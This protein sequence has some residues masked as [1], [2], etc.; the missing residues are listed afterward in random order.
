ML[1]AAALAIG[2]PVAAQSPASAPDYI[3][4]AAWLCL[5]GRADACA[6][7]LAATA[8]TP[9][10]YGAVEPFRRA[11]NPPLDCF[12]VYPTVSRDTTL[13]A[14]MEPGPAEAAVAA[15]QLARFASVCRTFAPLYRQVTLAGILRRF[16]GKPAAG[17]YAMAYGDVLAAW[18]NFLATRNAS[19]PFVLI[20]HSQGTV[21]LQQLLTRE[22]EG[23]PIAR[24]MVSALLIGFNTLVP[25]GK[26]VGGTF[27]S[28]PLCTRPAQTG[29]VV[30][31]VSY[32][33]GREPPADA[34][35]GRAPR[36]GMTVACTNPAAL[37]SARPASLR[38]YFY[39]APTLMGGAAKPWAREGTLGTQFVTTDG[40]VTGACVNRGPVGVLALRVNA[41]PRDARADD[42]PGD[43]V[44][45]GVVQ[46]GWG[47][48]LIDVNV[49]QGDLVRLV[50]RQAR[51]FGR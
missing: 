30:A 1:A 7:P 45:D 39:V 47:T 28:T 14:D 51:A 49:A 24:Q 46:A 23:K 18:R 34:L 2:A 33:A 41:D 4:D 36:P 6:A 25:E 9:R 21:H 22:I 10:G 31:Y 40:L 3:D 43:V 50:E 42:I 26:T 48:H 19:R 29:C 35:F 15:A 13:N 5:P 8:V 37:G 27:R 44:R 16:E 12:Y 20:G 17:D 38:P 32:R 11:A